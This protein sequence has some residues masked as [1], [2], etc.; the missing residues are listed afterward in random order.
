MLGLGA[1]TRQHFRFLGAPAA[2]ADSSDFGVGL[3]PE[4]VGTRRPC[5]GVG[6]GRLLGE[7]L[8]NLMCRRVAASLHEASGNDN[9]PKRRCRRAAQAHCK[10]LVP[11][12]CT[13]GEGMRTRATATTRISP[14]RARGDD[15]SRFRP[16]S[17]RL[18]N[19]D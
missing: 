16:E 14:A 6:L 9:E 18:M 19:D 10:R 11:H 4:L 8:G 5:Q 17:G 1:G 13:P 2:A 3:A 7:F 15:A 12:T